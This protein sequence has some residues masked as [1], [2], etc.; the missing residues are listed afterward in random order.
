MGTMQL[1]SGIVFFTVLQKL[2]GFLN[3]QCIGTIEGSGAGRFWIIPKANLG[4]AA[5]TPPIGIANT[6]TDDGGNP[7]NETASPQCAKANSPSL[8]TTAKFTTPLKNPCL[9]DLNSKTQELCS[10]GS[11]SLHVITLSP[12]LFTS[13]QYRIRIPRQER[14]HTANMIHMIMSAVDNISLKI[15]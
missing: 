2:S 4:L 11:S 1:I 13:Y 8:T 7:S 3:N 6:S 10:I 12:N 15:A 14:L 5:N 9:S